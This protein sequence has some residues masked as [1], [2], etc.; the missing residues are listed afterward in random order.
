MTAAPK[1]SREPI[2]VFL[3]ETPCNPAPF[4]V[5]FTS[6]R[7]SSSKRQCFAKSRERNQRAATRKIQPTIGTE[8]SS[9]RAL[10]S[11]HALHE[12]AYRS[13]LQLT[14]KEVAPPG[15][16]FLSSTQAR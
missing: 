14:S 5:L 12:R 9:A 1:T 16:P 10:H 11:S 8:A 3:T 15:Q 4:I 7:T 2:G 6:S 13:P